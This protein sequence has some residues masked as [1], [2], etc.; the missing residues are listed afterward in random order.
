MEI[1][2]ELYA[3]LKEQ[4]EF[5]EKESCEYLNM[6]YEANFKKFDQIFDRFDDLKNHQFRMSTETQAKIINEL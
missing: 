1:R 4:C 5:N 2:D 3:F 6:L